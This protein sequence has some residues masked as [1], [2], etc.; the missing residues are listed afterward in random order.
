MQVLPRPALAY[1]RQRCM[2]PPKAVAGSSQR[3]RTAGESATPKMDERCSSRYNLV[4]TCTPGAP[5]TTG[6][7]TSVSTTSTTTVQS[8]LVK[9]SRAECVRSTHT[10]MPHRMKST[11]TV[12]PTAYTYKHAVRGTKTNSSASSWPHNK[13]TH[14]QVPAEIHTTDQLATQSRASSPP[15]TASTTL[16]AAA[17][18]ALL[19]RQHCLTADIPSASLWRQFTC[20]PAELRPGC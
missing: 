9:S 17:V 8:C 5:L 1:V 12:A 20:V 14:T 11:P 6:A 4:S 19:R 2:Q 7:A 16:Q 10:P 3:G 13:A 15:P 18:T